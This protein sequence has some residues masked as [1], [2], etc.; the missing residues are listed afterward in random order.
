MENKQEFQ[1][2]FKSATFKMNNNGIL[3]RNVKIKS[4]FFNINLEII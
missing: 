2:I 1:I 4:K 3:K